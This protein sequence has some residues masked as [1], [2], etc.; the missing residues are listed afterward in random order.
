MTRVRHVPIRRCVA[1]RAAGPKRELIRLVRGEGGWALD[2]R[3]RAGG[4]GASLCP[5]CGLTAVRRDDPA[6]LKGLRRFFR[7]ETDAVTALL[8]A[9]EPA[10]AAAATATA[11]TDADAPGAAAPTPHARPRPNGGMHG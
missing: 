7:Q 8:S 11:T 6:R 5:A 9:I 1:C 2:L 3:Q 10:L 4:R